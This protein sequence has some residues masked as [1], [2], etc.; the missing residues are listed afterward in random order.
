M[1]SVNH[2]LLKF[3]YKSFFIFI[4]LDLDDYGKKYL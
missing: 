4:I 3:A 2:L 1:Y